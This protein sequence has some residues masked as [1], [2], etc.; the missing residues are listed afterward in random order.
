MDLA[1][2][3]KP[4]TRLAT[5]PPDTIS[6]VT[7]TA[8]SL[9]YASLRHKEHC[10]LGMYIVPSAE[11][12]MIWDAVLFVHQGY[13]MDSILKFRLTFPS[14]YPERPPVA[15]FLTDTFHPLISPQNGV[16][17]LAP[18]FRP[19]RPKEHHVFDVLHWI[20]AAFKKHALD[21]MKE[22]DCLNKEAFRLYHNT[23]SSFAALATQSSTLS[24]SS[25]T[26]SDRDYPSMPGRSRDGMPFR[27]LKPEQL[28]TLRSK[29]GLQEWDHGSV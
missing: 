3:S 12:L 21:E 26:L 25:S 24:R 16:F 23:T 19:W 1:Y 18:R 2:S 9:E 13:Y 17:N 6:P 11:T 15:H 14:N 22:S 10:P 20:K 8:V 27:E 29:I 5:V 28:S 7:H 4:R